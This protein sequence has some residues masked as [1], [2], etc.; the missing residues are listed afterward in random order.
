MPLFCAFDKENKCLFFAIVLKMTVLYVAQ[1]IDSRRGCCQMVSKE[2]C[3]EELDG[4]IYLN[5]NEEDS[6]KLSALQKATFDKLI[7]VANIAYKHV[8]FPRGDVYIFS[9]AILVG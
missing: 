5:N 9:S 1:G 8:L 3:K 4:K 2:T 6:F 7:V